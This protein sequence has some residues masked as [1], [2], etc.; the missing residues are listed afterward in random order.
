MDFHATPQCQTLGPSEGVERE[1]VCS[2]RCTPIHNQDSLV[3]GM[4][5]SSSVPLQGPGFGEWLFLL[6]SSIYWIVRR[7]QQGNFRNSLRCKKKNNK[8]KKATVCFPAFVKGS[9]SL[10]DITSPFD[11]RRLFDLY[12]MESSW[13]SAGS[14]NPLPWS[15]EGQDMPWLRGPCSRLCASSWLLRCQPQASVSKFS[16]KNIEPCWK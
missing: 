1:R 12:S 8:K 5:S 16:L 15:A 7:V 11:F 6:P 10:L 4:G 9:S 3:G 13:P 2:F 14:D